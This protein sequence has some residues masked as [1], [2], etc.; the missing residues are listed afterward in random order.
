MDEKAVNDQVIQ[1]LVARG[2]IYDHSGSLAV[3]V[4]EQIPGEPNRKTIQHF[5]LAALREVI[6]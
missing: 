6:S 3:I 5:S 1:A 4:D 2:D